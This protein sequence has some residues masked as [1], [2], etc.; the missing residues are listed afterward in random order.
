MDKKAKATPQELQVWIEARRRH[1]LS[2]A[3]VQMAREMGLNPRKLGKIDDHRQEPWKMPLPDFIED[4]YFKRFGR[5]RPEV[6][7]SIEE[8]AQRAEKKRA[9]RKAAR[10]ARRARATTEP[11][12]E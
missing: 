12:G 10:R 8:R 11:P 2:D 9:E 5:E 3:H 4:L 6:V 7:M 1:R